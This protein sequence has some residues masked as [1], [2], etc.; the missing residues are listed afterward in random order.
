MPESEQPR[1]RLRLLTFTTLFPSAARPR[2]GIFVET[3][4]RKLLATA[5][6]EATVIAPV[7]WF[8]AGSHVF[9]QYGV[10]AR[11]PASETRFDISVYHPRYFMIPKVGMLAQPGALARSAL[12]TIRKLM[13]G[14]LC[15]DL[16]DAHYFFPD[17]VAAAYLS[18]HLNKPYVITARGSDINL[19][20]RSPRPCRMILEAA[21]GA[22][23]II[24]VS[25]ALK[26]AMEGLGIDGDKIKVLRNGVDLETFSPVPQAVAR[27]VL[28][29]TPGRVV[30]SVGNLVPEKGHDLVLQAVALLKDV[31]LFIVGDGPERARLRSLAAS[32]RIPE[33][34]HILDA[35][36]QDRLKFAYSAADIL[37][38]GSTREGWPNVVLE[39]MACGTPV[40]A[41][42]VGGV[43]EIIQDLRVGSLVPDRDPAR[44]ASAVHAMLASLPERRLVRLFSERFGWEAVARAQAD[45]M[46]SVVNGR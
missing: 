18:R 27:A 10:Y 14:G 32:L 30:L 40:V 41:T 6:V 36:S 37:A 35:M 5:R 21:R 33:R 23:R 15:F 43:P 42:S 25:E 20:A 22:S 31:H 34:V 19:I 8:P 17:G 28:D 39:A 29:W 3:R 11:T 26:R 12:R 7:P 2:H 9:G 38:L 44:F 16:I 13:H 45:L 24:A 46:A 4:L 1:R